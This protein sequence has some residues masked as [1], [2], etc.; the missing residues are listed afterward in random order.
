MLLTPPGAGAIAVLRLQGPGVRGFLEMN[1]STGA[2]AAAQ[3]RHGT[4]SDGAQVIDDPVVVLFGDGQTADINLHGG[5]WVVTA[6]LKLAQRDGFVI[7]PPS[8]PLADGALDA[9]SILEREVLSH[10]PLAT[11]ELAISVLL[12]QIGAWNRL[13]AE[14]PDAAQI[15]AILG[16]RSLHWMLHAPRVAIVGAPNVG[17]STLANRLFARERS[18]TADLPG[19]TR[20]WVG[21][22]ANLDG[23]AVMLVDTPGLR[24]TDDAIEREAIQRSRAQVDRADLVLH[25]EDITQPAVSLVDEAG[26]WTIRVLNKCDRPSRREQDRDAVRVCAKTGDGIEKL[27]ERVK[28][29]FGCAAINLNR[30]RWWT[31]RQRG[32]LKL[33][34]SDPRLLRSRND[35]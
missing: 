26:S 25:V 18:I 27:I 17:K 31:E 21:E 1:F 4:L 23:L 14:E 32:L 9:N 8:M 33:A 24:E 15:E 11:T 10:L 22:M 28:A 12:N 5:I 3:C 13:V 6:A 29:F 30:P 16:D 34:T 19:T 35:P 2:P 7:E 20:D